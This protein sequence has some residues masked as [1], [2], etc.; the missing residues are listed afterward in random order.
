V[1]ERIRQL[2]A[3]AKHTGIGEQFLDLLREIQERLST[4]PLG[5]GDPLHWYHHLDLLVLRL[6][7][8]FVSVHYCVDKVRRIVYVQ[9]VDLLPWHPLGENR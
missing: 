1:L 4:D 5:S 8:G 3:R 9:E 7:C 6:H 2:A